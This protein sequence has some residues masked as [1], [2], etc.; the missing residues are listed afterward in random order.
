MDQALRR[1]GEPNPA[2]VWWMNLERLCLGFLAAFHMRLQMPSIGLPFPNKLPADRACD[3]DLIP[4][5]EVAAIH[6]P[7]LPARLQ[8]A[9]VLPLQS[10]G[11]VAP[12][13]IRILQEA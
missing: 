11:V 6:I 9:D 13:A 10:Y 5:H 2:K 1:T 4:V 12:R 7:V 3:G 8:A